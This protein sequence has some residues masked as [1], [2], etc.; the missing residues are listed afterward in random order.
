MARKKK[1]IK[2]EAPKVKKERIN[3]IADDD[4]NVYDPKFPYGR[5]K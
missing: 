5:G 1:V 4:P 2:K 3:D